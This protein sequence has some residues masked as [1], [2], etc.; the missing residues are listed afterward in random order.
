MPRA[1]VLGDP[2]E[3]SLS[4]VLHNAGYEALGLEEWWYT[5]HRV[6]D[7]GLADFVAAHG[8]EYRGFSV[9]MPAKFAALSLAG[10]V[11]ERARLV[12][13]ANTLIHTATGWR[14]DNTDCEG[15]AGALAELLGSARPQ[16]AVVV[17]AGGTARP[18]LW[19]LAGFGVKEVAIV[20]R[21]DRLSELA[22]L[23]GALGLQV[24]A[25]SYDDD[26]A[27]LSKGADVVV[28]TVPSAAV[29]HVVRELAHAPVFDVIYEPSPTPL[30]I[31]AAANGYPTVGGHV[32]LA[33]Q[34]YSQFE[35]FT[36][37][38]APREEMRAAL[39]S[40]LEHRC[41]FERRPVEHSPADN[42]HA[43]GTD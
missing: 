42:V 15:A 14:A 28:S 13:S 32:M 4:P 3:H 25:A 2:I 24:S 43:F 27:K 10:D 36:G 30:T 26:L 35:Q 23:S 37:H 33:Y 29:K 22:A 21:R 12:G 20:N 19:A 31:A 17:G 7:A 16:R 18:V 1:A 6:D 34:S 41:A 9:T 39:V 38:E 11:T 5:R 40:A 8:D